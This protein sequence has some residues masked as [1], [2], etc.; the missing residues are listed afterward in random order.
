MRCTHSIVYDA[1]GT[2]PD[3]QTQAHLPAICACAKD[4]CRTI[5]LRGEIMKIQVNGQ[6]KLFAEKTSLK[7]TD[8][9][10]ELDVKEQ[11]GIAIAVNDRVIP[12]SQW[13]Q[14]ELADG[15]VIEIIRATQGG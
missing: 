10:A 7:L 1:Q 13:I 2:K 3:K 4:P 6:D 14:A 9:L 12:K 5:R 8:I 11:R 15:D